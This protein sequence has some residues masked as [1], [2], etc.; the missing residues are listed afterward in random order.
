MFN[1]TT[2]SKGALNFT[3]YPAQELHSILA[4]HFGDVAQ[5]TS[6]GSSCPRYN[7]LFLPRVQCETLRANNNHLCMNITDS[8]CRLRHRPQHTQ[9][10]AGKIVS[11][12]GKQ[13]DARATSP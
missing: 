10:H 6:Y 1:Y 7:H 3:D 11:I 8:V 13:G 2:N 5:S 9:M 12:K 4:F